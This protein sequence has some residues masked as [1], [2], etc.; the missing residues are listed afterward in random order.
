MPE[1]PHKDPTEIRVVSPLRFTVDLENDRKVTLRVLTGEDETIMIEMLG[2]NPSPEAFT[3]AFIRHQIMGQQ[4]LEVDELSDADLRTLGMAF[5]ARPWCF[6]SIIDEEDEFFAAFHSA[7]KRYRDAW[8][9]K[10]DDLSRS[11]T[12]RTIDALTGPTSVLA[13]AQSTLFPDHLVGAHGLALGLG[14]N[15]IDPSL[16]GGSLATSAAD[17]AI[18]S[19]W[20]GIINPTLSPLTDFS[21][22]E[23]AQM[24]GSSLTGEQLGITSSLAEVSAQLVGDFSDRW[25]TALSGAIAIPSMDWLED[26]IPDWWSDLQERTRDNIATIEREFEEHEFAF[27]FRF[28]QADFTHQVRDLDTAERDRQIAE[29]AIQTSQSEQFIESLE[30]YFTG[31][32]KL[33]PRLKAVEAGIED[34]LSERYWASVPTLLSQCE[35]I[36]TDIIT[37]HD[38]AYIDGTKVRRADNNAEVKGMQPKAEFIRAMEQTLLSATLVTALCGRTRVLRNGVLHGTDTSY[39]T[40]RNSAAAILTLAALAAALTK[41]IGGQRPQA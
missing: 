12:L 37:L 29:H 11:R 7:A 19:S 31:H 22:V 33:E 32:A 3:R 4:G 36:L 21:A 20:A 16:F 25:L 28:W 30:T 27:S 40:L 34:H 6:D 10:L 8:R 5:S 41:S 2:D 24:A 38:W 1:S 14:Q 15:M 17:M 39:G 13:A 18:T 23:L 26:T 35:G 9:N